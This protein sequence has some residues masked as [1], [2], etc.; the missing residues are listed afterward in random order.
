[1]NIYVWSGQF[2]ES[3]KEF[4]SAG[5]YVASGH[6]KEEAV[7]K[8]REKYLENCATTKAK[9]VD[10]LIEEI[11]KEKDKNRLAGLHRG[12]ESCASGVRDK[13]DVELSQDFAQKL[14]C[15]EP[16]IYALEELAVYEEPVG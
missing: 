11:K 9:T 8:L 6:N 2:I 12:L 3:L 13:Q 7:E 10:W 5:L 4:Y 14:L 1:M 15:A 16:K